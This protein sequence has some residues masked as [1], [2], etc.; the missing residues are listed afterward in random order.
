MKR[1]PSP[2]Q[3]FLGFIC[4]DV[5][6]LLAAVLLFGY[7][8]SH[9]SGTE[10]AS[11]VTAVPTAAAPTSLSPSPRFTPTPAP[12]TTP[13]PMQTAT[14]AS[15]QFTYADEQ[16]TVTDRSQ[17]L[18]T[19]AVAIT[20]SGNIP[21]VDIQSLPPLPGLSQTQFEILARSAVQTYFAHP[22]EVISLEDSSMSQTE[23]SVRLDLSETADSPRLSAHVRLLLGGQHSILVVCLLS[24]DADMETAETFQAVWA[25]VTPA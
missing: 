15:F 12:T 25:S 23:Y 21:R 11:T 3:L 19:D 9:R 4:L 14:F 13:E 20:A 17:E 18:E 6:L 24:E 22:P 10:K 7:I 5:L 16:L 1:K 2:K 8:L